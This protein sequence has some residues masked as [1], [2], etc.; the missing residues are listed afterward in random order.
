M[1]LLYVIVFFRFLHLSYLIILIC[2]HFP[3]TTLL[4]QLLQ[5]PSRLH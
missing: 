3:L 2:Q 5:S 4:A 1:W